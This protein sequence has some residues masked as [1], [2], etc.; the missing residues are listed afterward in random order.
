[1]ATFG[2]SAP[3]QLKSEEGFL[4]DIRRL[5]VLI[6]RPKERLIVVCAQSLIDHTPSDEEAIV[7]HQRLQKLHY[8]FCQ[9]AKKLSFGTHRLMMSWRI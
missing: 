2:I 8:Q 3:D 9:R 7:G 6:S 1:M 5:N 4:Y